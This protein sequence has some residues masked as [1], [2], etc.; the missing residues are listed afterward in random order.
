MK[1]LDVDEEL[2]NSPRRHLNRMILDH[3][4]EGY[5]DELTRDRIPVTVTESGRKALVEL[6]L[7]ENQSP[8]EI[9]RER[10][11]SLGHILKMVDCDKV[12]I[13]DY[14]VKNPEEE[15]DRIC[16]DHYQD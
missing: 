1:S 4:L 12:E 15:F 11:D 13:N 3:E 2:V 14:F 6:A 9:F 16:S 5:V 8:M 10:F 7:E